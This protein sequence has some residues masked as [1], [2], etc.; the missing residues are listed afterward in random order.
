MSVKDCHEGVRKLDPLMVGQS[1]TVVA[2]VRQQVV[3]A[4]TEVDLHMLRKDMAAAGQILHIKNVVAAFFSLSLMQRVV[5]GGGEWRVNGVEKVD[6]VAGPGMVP[7]CFAPLAVRPNQGMVRFREKVG[8]F[9]GQVSHVA[10]LS[11][12]LSVA[13]Q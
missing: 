1:M 4:G 3:E 6:E 12:A 8:T 10:V 2:G 7:T 9:K 13:W 5:V 11:V